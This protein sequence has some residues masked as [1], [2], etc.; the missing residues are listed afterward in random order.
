MGVASHDVSLAAEAISRLRAAGTPCELELLFG[1][2]MAESMRWARENGVGVRVYVPFGKG[3]IPS[4]IGLLK[5][6][7]R[8]GLR[9]LR[10]LVSEKI[11]Q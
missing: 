1:R 6:N 4:A 9:I 2:P 3:Y 10:G 8:L 7:S 11:A 5:H